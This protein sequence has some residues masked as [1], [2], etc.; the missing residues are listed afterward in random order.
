M[1]KFHI[2]RSIQIHAPLGTVSRLTS[3]FS[4]WPAWSPWLCME[5]D[6]QIDAYGTPGQPDHGYQWKGELVGEGEMQTASI[7]NGVHKMVLTFLKPFRSKANVELHLDAVTA[8]NTMAT[9]HMYGALPIFMFF[10]TD[11]MKSMIGMDYERGLKMLKEYAETGKVNSKTDITGIVEAPGTTYVG[12][13]TQSSINDLQKSMKTTFPMADQLVNAANLTRTTVPAGAI[14][15]DMNIKTQQ[16]RY[17]A[18]IPVS[19]EPTTNESAQSVSVKYIGNSKALKVVHHGSYTHLGNS[20][21]AAM[22]YQRYKKLKSLKGHPPFELYL[23][24]PLTT[25]ETD[26]LT[27]IYIPLKD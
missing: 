8:N 15:N 25:D 20:W 18:F 26:L 9:W 23:N 24:D 12:V 17:T 22:S 6:A 27:E 2:E 21:A 1:P 3:D 10:M 19:A 11:T 4:E 7:D 5:P 13:D 16:C 14:Y